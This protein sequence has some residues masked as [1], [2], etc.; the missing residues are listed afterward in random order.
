MIQAV[1][2]SAMMSGL[3]DRVRTVLR[4]AFSRALSP[5][6]VRDAVVESGFN[7]PPG[8]SNFMAEI[9]TILKRLETQGDITSTDTEQGKKYCHVFRLGKGALVVAEVPDLAEPPK[10]DPAESLK[11]K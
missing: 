10:P 4:A 5:V 3:T 11:E 2:Q 7:V 6:E 8:R 1:I 9:H